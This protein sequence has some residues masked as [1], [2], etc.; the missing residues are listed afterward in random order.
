MEQGGTARAEIVELAKLDRVR[1][2][3]SRDVWNS[4]RRRRMARRRG[5]N[6]TIWRGSDVDRSSRHHLPGFLQHG[7]REVR[8]ILR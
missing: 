2:A 5:D 3:G 8:A 4:T 7:M 6:R 1:R